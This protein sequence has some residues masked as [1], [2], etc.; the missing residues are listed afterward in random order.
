MATDIQTGPDPR[1][2][3]PRLSELVHGIVHDA[4]D[5]V[6]QQLALFKTEVRDEIHKTRDAALSLA[7]GASIGVLGVILLAF[8]IVH[9]LAWAFPAVPLWAWFIIVGGVLAVAGFAFLWEGKH[10]IESLHAVPEQSAEALKENVQWLMN[11]K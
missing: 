11:P 3:E 9:L 1:L 10:R 4:E 7:V 6:K 8:G 5:L 2:N